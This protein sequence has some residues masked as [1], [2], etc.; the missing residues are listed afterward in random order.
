MRMLKKWNI[1]LK[2]FIQTLM[3]FIF[4]VGC[5]LK[6]EKKQSAVPREETAQVEVSPLEIKKAVERVEVHTDYILD[7]KIELSSNTVIRSQRIFLKRN[8]LIQ[9]NGFNLTF[10]AKHIFSD[11]AQI[12]TFPEGAEAEVTANGK[13]GGQIRF[14]AKQA[15]GDLQV[16]LRGENGRPGQN[17]QEYTT[18]AANGIQGER[19]GN[20]CLRWLVGGPIKC[21]CTRN[22]TNGANGAAGLKGQRGQDGGN[23]GSSGT[24]AIEIEDH[25]NFIFD[26]SQIPGRGGSPGLGGLGQKG[27]KGGPPGNPTSTEC[28]AAFYGA[29]GADG[30]QG[31][32]GLR[33]L[34]GEREQNIYF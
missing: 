31:D 11:H 26:V 24:I 25:S 28:N 10:R 19:G 7:K 6:V 27:G 30:P 3:L 16:I 15:I 12:I 1:N 22:P 20:Q 14:V 18:A 4:L 17:G 2:F 29:D 23:G 8:S 34:D 9:T 33:G 21:I 5:G 32:A 13:S